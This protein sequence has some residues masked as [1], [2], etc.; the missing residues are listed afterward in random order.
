MHVEQPG[1]RALGRKGH[2]READGG[3]RRA[4][5]AVAQ[6][7][8]RHLAPDAGLG[9]LGASADVRRQ[10]RAVDADERRRERRLARG[11]LLGEDVHRRPGEVSADQRTTQGLEIH[12][13]PA[14]RV[15]QDRARSHAA[16]LALADQP[17]RVGRVRDVE[18]HGVAPLEE[19][20]EV[21]GGLDVPEGQL[22]GHVVVEHAHAEHLGQH[23]H[24]A[25]DVP[26]ADDA[27]GLA[28]RLVA[29][30]GG[31]LPVPT[32]AAH[33]ALGDAPQEQDRLRDHELRHAARVRVG[34]VEHRHAA[35]PREAV[36]HLV[37]PDAEA[38]D[39]DELPRLRQDLGRELGP[40][41]DPDHVGRA[42]RGD[43][44]VAGQGP[45]VGLH[46]PVAR[47]AEGLGG[48]VADPLEEDDADLRARK[49]G[50]RHGVRRM[51]YP[52][53]R[54]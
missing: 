6:Q 8:R 12:D 44:L 42:D 19:V 31:L 54:G 20:V 27:D 22:G 9:L 18:G 29:P 15:D 28:A 4:V 33:V 50:L 17:D 35:A 37:G 21:P 34:R 45:R 43:Q 14:R 16:K 53:P 51:R 3:E 32:V 46:V 23:A 48:G 26:V 24:L 38:A 30:G 1:A 13:L 52:P 36:V 39:R 49:G 40:R 10:Q 5:V 11:R 47:F 2:L 25:A 41:A 7:L